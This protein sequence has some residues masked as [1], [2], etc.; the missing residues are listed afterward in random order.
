MTKIDAYLSGL[1][2]IRRF[3]LFHLLLRKIDPRPKKRPKGDYIWEF[4]RMYYQLSVWPYL[5]APD[6]PDFAPKRQS[7]FIRILKAILRRPNIF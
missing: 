3:P 7:L 1:R 5:V 6:I 4:N 2:A